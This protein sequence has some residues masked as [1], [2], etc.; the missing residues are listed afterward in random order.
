MG[1]DSEKKIVWMVSA[2]AQKQE[3]SKIIIGHWPISRK[4]VSAA[5]AKG[6]ALEW[7]E[8]KKPHS[9]GWT[10]YSVNACPVFTSDH[11]RLVAEGKPTQ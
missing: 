11:E 9:E 8:D 1:A 3:G 4:A 5:E 10:N 2:F 6:L 7:L